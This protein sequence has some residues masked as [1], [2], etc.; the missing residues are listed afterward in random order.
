MAPKSLASPE[1]QMLQ[2]WLDDYS[3]NHQNPFNQM[4]HRYS[5]PVIMLGAL[6]LLAAI[7]APLFAG[8]W[9]VAL[10]LMSVAF[11]STL[12]VRLATGMAVFALILFTALG[13]LALLPIPLWITCLTLFV[14][15]GASQLIGHRAEP[16]RVSFRR[17]ARLIFV[18]P[19]WLMDSIL[20]RLGVADTANMPQTTEIP[21]PQSVAHGVPSAH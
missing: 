3:N 15:A 9:A 1:R 14:V 8:F 21:A 18:S 13:L 20:Q 7:P 12:S 4:I 2:G 19:L 16:T 17:D 10:V 5:I 6:G 11:Y